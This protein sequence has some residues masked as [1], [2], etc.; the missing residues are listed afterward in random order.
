[1]KAG[2]EGGGKKVKEGRKEGRTDGRTDGRKE[3]R[4]QNV[5]EREGRAVPVDFIRLVHVAE[6]KGRNERR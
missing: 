5:K 2:K 3:G 1:M 6:A 4:R